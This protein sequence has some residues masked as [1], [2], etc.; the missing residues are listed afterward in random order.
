VCLRLG[1]EHFTF[2]FKGAFGRDV[3]DKFCESYLAGRTPNPCIDCNRYLKFDALQRRRTEMGAD[4]VA[5]GHYARTH[6]N[7]AT[8]RW[9]LLRAADAT[10]DQSYVLYHLTQDLL[11]HMVFPLGDLTKP[12][13]REYARKLGLVTADKPE[14]QDICFVPDGNY[15]AF[16]AKRMQDKREAGSHANDA[17]ESN[18]SSKTVHSSITDDTGFAPGDIVGMEGHILGQHAGLVRYTPGQRRGIGV[19]AS[20]PL[21][22]FEKDIV[23]NRLVVGFKNEVNVS[24]I[25]VDDVNFVS[26]AGFDTPTPVQVK[27]HYRARPAN[28][29]VI[30]HPI[31]TSANSQPGALQGIKLEIQFDEPH[32]VCA[33]GQAAVIYDGDRVLAGGTISQNIR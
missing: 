2:N 24:G 6:F 19:A 1:I 14:S 13:V 29:T 22:V 8:G 27:T 23:N 18:T 30:A 12:E 21:Y 5:T 3:M 20:E 4:M 15:A 31:E 28:A 33:P 17:L 7:D 25:L 16:I 32:M 11:A 9:E 10:K 26:A